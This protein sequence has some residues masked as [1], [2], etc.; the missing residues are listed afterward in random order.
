MNT[1]HYIVS[2]I[3]ILTPLAVLAQDR[4]TTIIQ[5]INMLPENSKKET[6]ESM[7][8][9]FAKEGGDI[10]EI[11]ECILKATNSGNYEIVP[12]VEAIVLPYQKDI[13][14]LLD[15][16]LHT[17]ISIGA[18]CN[19][20]SKAIEYT[21][22]AIELS[23]QN[24]LHKKLFSS[25]DGHLHHAW[26]NIAVN[27]ER[28]GDLKNTAYAY[29]KAAKEIKK[30]YPTNTKFFNDYLSLSSYMM[31]RYL[32]ETYTGDKVYR[33]CLPY[34]KEYSLIGN[35]EGLSTLW[36]LF[37]NSHNIVALTLI[38]TKIIPNEK[39][40]KAIANY[41]YVTAEKFFHDELYQEAL[42]YYIDLMAISNIN[43]FKNYLFI[44][45]EG[46]NRSRFEYVAHCFNKL[47]D[48]ENF[49]QSILNELIDVTL[50]FGTDSEEFKYYAVFLD[51]LME[52][53]VKGQILQKKMEEMGF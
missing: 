36:N 5:E 49:I 40:Q 8:K 51:N 32:T 42:D 39:D 7:L 15:Y 17:G 18:L 1:I 28:L 2:A 41:Y 48:D 26:D 21:E 27:Y 50:E 16:Y 44:E 23:E 13:N 53:P 45:I 11:E 31:Y 29:L 43:K 24:N 33:E 14:S 34:L 30:Y 35:I 47:G 25:F 22:K 4:K 9:V 20:P 37:V 19:Q 12:V 38:D 46:V 10:K 3:L 52:D 6:Y